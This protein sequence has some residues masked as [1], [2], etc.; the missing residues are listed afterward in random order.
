VTAV[1]HNLTLPGVDLAALAAESGLQKVGGRPPL[2]LY[3]KQIW[4]RRHFTI[5][6]ARGMTTG[7][8][9]GT[10]LTVLWELITPILWAGLYLFIFGVLVKTNRGTQNFVGF[11]VTGLFIFRFVAGCLTLGARSIKKQQGL[12]TSLQFPRA[13]VPMAAATAELF[14]LIPALFV[15]FVLALM[16]HEPIRWQML[17]FIPAIA[18]M[19]VFTLGISMISAR[20]VADVPD[21]VNVLPFVTRFMMYVS[22]VFFSIDHFVGKGTL[23]QVLSYQPLAVYIELARSALLTEISVKTSTWAWAFG[24]AVLVFCIGFVFFWRAEAKYG[25]G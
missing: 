9:E 24:W 4:E 12:I 3:I 21:L 2:T 10:R 5:E 16:S 18:L 13:L 1:G 11:L 19:F 23:G 25:R 15:L 17:L 8:N 20:I 7:S 14:S 22:G 6:M